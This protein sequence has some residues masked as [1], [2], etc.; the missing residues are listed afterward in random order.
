MTSPYVSKRKEGAHA[1]KCTVSIRLL[2]FL[3][4][5]HPSK[6]VLRKRWPA[7]Q[8]LL[9]LAIVLCLSLSLYL[10]GILDAA[11]DLRYHLFGAA[12]SFCGSVAGEI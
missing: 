4:I 12:V 3:Q 8:P 2:F 11:N 10:N 7:P 6:E 5:V 9:T 1:V